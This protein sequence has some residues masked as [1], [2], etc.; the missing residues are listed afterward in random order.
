MGCIRCSIVIFLIIIFSHSFTFADSIIIPHN[1]NIQEI[2]SELDHKFYP[3]SEHPIEMCHQVKEVPNESLNNLH[4]SASEAHQINHQEISTRE[5][6]NI[7]TIGNNFSLPFNFSFDNS[8]KALLAINRSINLFT[9]KIKEKFALWLQRSAKYLQIMKDI[10]KEKNMPTDLVFLPLIESGFNLNAYSRAHAVGP[11]QFI[12]S[13]GKRYGLIIDWWRDERKDPIKSTKAAANYLKDLYRMFGSWELA[14]AAYNAG[15]GRILK[16]LKKSYSDD[17]WDLLRTNHIKDETKNYVPHF[18]AAALIAKK[19]EDFGFQLIDYHEPLKFDEI[20][21]HEPV[22]LDIIAQCANTTIYEIKQLN[23][24]LRRWSTPPNVLK[25][26]LRLPANSKELFWENLN[27]IP[28]NQ[29]FSYDTYKVKKG[30][31]IR[32]ISKKLKIPPIAIIEL[33]GLTG[34]ESFRAGDLIKIPP[35]H[36]FVMDI[37]DKKSVVKVSNKESTKQNQSTVKN[38]KYSQPNNNKAKNKI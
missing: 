37:S 14:L 33:N 10:L 3:F 6:V 30:E 19:P 31:N 12:E 38:K 16:A 20:T 2:H 28:P 5:L 32:T 13:T 24:E 17:F 35:K 1:N 23:A 29:R 26:T 27:A 22:D 21:L 4:S 7:L 11:W 25:Y 15:E 9:N 34:L 18:I 36:K 8:D